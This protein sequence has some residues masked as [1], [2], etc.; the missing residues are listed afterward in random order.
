VSEQETTTRREKKGSQ[1]W[2]FCSVNDDVGD[3][4]H[5]ISFIELLAAAGF[6]YKLKMSVLKLQRERT[7]IV[8]YTEKAS[9]AR[10]GRLS[11]ARSQLL[12]EARGACIVLINCPQQRTAG[13]SSVGQWTLKCAHE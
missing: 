1:G 6:V 3:E 12:S 2:R 5:L 9:S 8:G 7:M 13:E 10:P 11:P 4:W